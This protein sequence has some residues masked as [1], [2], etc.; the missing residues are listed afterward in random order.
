MLTRTSGLA[1]YEHSNGLLGVYVPIGRRKALVDWFH[2]SI[3]HLGAD[4]TY[5]E[6]INSYYW[7]SC[8]SDVRKWCAL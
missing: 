2:R 5:A 1:V 7:P 6:V 8:H 3:E 4:K